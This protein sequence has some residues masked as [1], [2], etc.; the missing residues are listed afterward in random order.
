MKYKNIYEFK[1]F[2]SIINVKSNGKE[3]V[4]YLDYDVNLTPF[5]I[6]LYKNGVKYDDLNIT[7]PESYRLNKKEFF[8]NPNI[9]KDIVNELVIQNFMAETYQ[10]AVAGDIPTKSYILTI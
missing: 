1:E 9:D 5:I 10:D 8:L 2:N 4:Y 3:S 7:I 6:T